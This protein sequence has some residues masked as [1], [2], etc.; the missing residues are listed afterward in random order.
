MLKYLFFCFVGLLFLSTAQAQSLS[1]AAI[2][3]SGGYF[4]A[5]SGIS[6]ST[7]VAE[8]TLPQTYKAAINNATYYLTQGF[9]QPYN[10]ENTGINEFTDN[11]GAPFIYP[12]PS[13]GIIH[14]ALYYTAAGTVSIVAHDIL[15]RTAAVQKEVAYTTGLQTQDQTLQWSNLASGV[16]F[17]TVSYES[18]VTHQL[19][20]QTHKLTIVKSN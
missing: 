17:I 4:V 18:A 6:L 11:N 15:G 10:V 1:V 12:N 16:Y 19:T 2:S 20:I 7:T 14:V 13:T 9:Q 3:A 8:M 5:S